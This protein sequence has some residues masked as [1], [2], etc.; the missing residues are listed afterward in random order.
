MGAVTAAASGLGK[1]VTGVGKVVASPVFSNIVQLAGV[2]TQAVGE[3]KTGRVEAAAL[4]TDANISRR[5][6]EII[7]AT[8]EFETKQLKRQ[9][10]KMSGAQRA[11]F[12]KAGVIL[13][14]T[15]LDVIRESEEEAEMDILVNKINRDIEKNRFLTRAVVTEAEAAI[16]ERV[17]TVKA[18]RTL[19]TA[20]PQVG[21]VLG[22]FQKKRKS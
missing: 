6:A 22:E 7:E 14:G 15:P 11:A 19:L 5:E 16:A 20:I 3:V 1:I 21:Q 13:E 2:G 18:G 9:K 4:R 17:G 12:S 8:R 10:R